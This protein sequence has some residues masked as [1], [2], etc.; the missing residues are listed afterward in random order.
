[1]NI[2]KDAPKDENLEYLKLLLSYQAIPC[3]E[4][5]VSIFDISGYPHYENV[6]SNILA[7]YLNPFKEHGLSSLLLSALLQ[8]TGNPDEQRPRHI[9]VI[10]EFGTDNGGRLDIAIISDKYF[11]GI[12]NKIFYELSNNLA[13]YKNTI[14]RH[15]DS[16]HLE[17]IR[18]LLTL[19]PTKISA[20]TGFINIDY[21]TLWKEVRTK[22]GFYAKST[23]QKW[24]SYLIDF[25][26]TTQSFTGGTMEFSSTDLFFIENN[27][28]IEKFVK[29][30]DS[31][32]MKLNNRILILKE[33]ISKL[34]PLPKS[35]D[36]QWVYASSCL[37]HDYNLSG[38][39]IAFDLNITPKGWILQLFARNKRSEIYLNKLVKPRCSD[40]NIENNRFIVSKWPLATDLN[41]IGRYLC[42]WMT[43]IDNQHFSLIQQK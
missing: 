42:E 16:M 9:D 15:A 2:I 18:I 1:M 10:R 4:K 32:L 38:N 41:E 30:R 12:E 33:I 34:A 13:D 19:Q 40:L 36:S 39:K 3:S 6:C 14:D 20:D 31:F 8:L 29:D 21:P 5:Q 24:M 27:D 35:L 11:I 25:M 23:S 43:W 37:V 28:L 7:F 22:F 17:P 26:D